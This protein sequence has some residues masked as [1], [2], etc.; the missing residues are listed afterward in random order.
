VSDEQNGVCS[1]LHRGLVIVAL[2]IGM[3]LYYIS[4]LSL[5]TQIRYQGFCVIEKVLRAN[6]RRAVRVGIVDQIV[7]ASL[8]FIFHRSSHSPQTLDQP[9]LPPPAHRQHKLPAIIPLFLAV[10]VTQ[11]S[12]VEP[13]YPAD[14]CKG[15]YG[16]GI[17]W[18][19]GIG[20]D[21]DGCAAS[22]IKFCESDVVGWWD[23]AE[24]ESGWWGEEAIE[25]CSEWP[26]FQQE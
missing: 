6:W 5:Q 2:F 14:P 12:R 17:Q 9:F 8:L 18:C 11:Y 4:Q 22:G 25:M 24:L 10:R 19:E 23:Q 13:E 3:Q 21:Q 7:N 16:H 1:S 26:Q 20:Q 15:C